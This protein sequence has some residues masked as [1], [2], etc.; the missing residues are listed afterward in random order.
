[1]VA[2][3]DTDFKNFV[4]GKHVRLPIPQSEVLNNPNLKQ[5]P[6]Y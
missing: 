6:G 4:I 1:M 3:R 2:Q 5:N